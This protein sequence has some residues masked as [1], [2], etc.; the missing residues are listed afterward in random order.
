MKIR[1]TYIQ[2]CICATI[3]IFSSNLIAQVEESPTY[4]VKVDPKGT[5]LFTNRN[6]Y[7]PD[8]DVQKTIPKDYANSPSVFDLTQ[9][10]NHPV[11]PL[12]EGDV[13]TFEL[14][15]Y[16]QAGDQHTD[17]YASLGAVFNNYHT[18]LSP[19][20]YTNAGP[21]PSPPTY[22]NGWPTD[23]PQDFYIP[24]GRVVY[25]QVPKGAT[26]ILFTVWD[27]FFSDNS[28]PNGDFGVYI[29][30]KIFKPYRIIS[31]V[32]VNRE[33]KENRPVDIEPSK[34]GGCK[35]E[36]KSA[37][38]KVFCLTKAPG[39]SVEEVATGCKVKSSIELSTNLGH[40]AN[41][42][43]AARP[44]GSLEPNSGAEFIEI[45][46]AGLD[47]R[48]ITSE[49]SG[50]YVVRLVGQ[51]PDGDLINQMGIG[52]RVATQTPFV[53]LS[54]IRGFNF[55]ELNSHPE[56]MIW[57]TPE[58]YSQ[59]SLLVRDYFY[60]AN[61]TPLIGGIGPIWQPNPYAN[62]RISPLYS[63]GASLQYG[64]LFDINKD[65]QSPH[66]GHRNGRDIDISLSTFNNG[67]AYLLKKVL[68]E[69][70]I[71]SGFR[72][73]VLKESPDYIFA[74]HWHLRLK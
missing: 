13:L 6:P 31:R 7:H 32:F 36:N 2:I 23:I 9:L 50:G 30:I 18:N 37:L 51:N 73:P 14:V 44:K 1:M 35:S 4:F 63:Q 43:Q 66:C 24:N 70:I 58:M 56:D 61:N 53:S 16:F 15:G 74:D 26:R 52:F 3:L 17:T 54:G 38:I 67:S 29:K 47:L 28:D 46:A 45:P 12:Q 8:P 68:A 10:Y 49:V 5:Y 21:F 62:I 34:I 59:L 20:S 57:G 65:W 39:S 27:S 40:T 42:N 60:S 64:G 33:L 48:Y 69:R 19:G 41:H 11:F 25:A 71:D 22:H 55:H 72:T